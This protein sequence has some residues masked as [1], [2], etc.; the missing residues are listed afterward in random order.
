M[1]ARPRAEVRRPLW[2]ALGILLA[3]PVGAQPPDAISAPP[4]LGATLRGLLDHARAANPE[5]RAMRLE[6]D[7]AV[8][9]ASAAGALRDPMFEIELRDVTNEMGGGGFSLSPANVGSTKYTVW[10]TLPSWGSRQARRTAAS[11]SADASAS[12]A[13]ATWTELAAR[14]KT[15]YARYQQV[16]DALAQS[17]EVLGLIEQLEAVA[18]VR[19]AAG[20]APQQDAIRAQ[21]ERT[22]I[23]AEIAALEAELP[24]L[25]ARL[26]GLLA[27]APDAPLAPPRAAPVLPPIAALDDAALRERVLSRNP[28][29][30][31]EGARVRAAEGNRDVVYSNRYPEFG[32]GVSPV[33]RGSRIAEWELRFGINLPLQQSSRRAEEGEAAALLAAAQARRESLRNDILAQLGESRAAYDSARRIET[34]TA[35]SLLPQAEVTLQSALAG[36]E[37]GRVDFATV[38]DAQRQIRQARLSLIRLRAEARIRLA[39]IERLLGEDL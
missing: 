4:E 24:A 26:N 18:Q 5:L 39:E 37:S 13:H 28:Q 15:S 22:A 31:A 23:L 27:R 29:L 35:M 12:L 11:A 10:Q 6:A 34:L 25:R 2:V 20:L 32:F 38:L 36:Y 16:S 30:A 3:C 33:Q 21:V 9:R 7:A 19:Y 8:Q 14:I 1:N 17:R